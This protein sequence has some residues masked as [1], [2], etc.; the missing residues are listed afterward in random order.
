MS[1]MSQEETRIGGFMPSDPYTV[2]PSL[3]WFPTYYPTWTV[4]QSM[5]TADEVR[6][7]VREELERQRAIDEGELLETAERKHG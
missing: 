4:P 1:Q 6:Q 5:L 7:I 3:W 2:D